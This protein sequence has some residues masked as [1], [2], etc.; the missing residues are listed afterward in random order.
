MPDARSRS[1]GSMF[2]VLEDAVL[3]ADMGLAI[4]EVAGMAA[5]SARAGARAC[6]ADRRRVL[7]GAHV[8]HRIPGLASLD[9][10][11]AQDRF[12]LLPFGDA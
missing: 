11:L 2:V 6:R 5:P 4:A 10:Q 1:R 7:G 9:F 8:A 12:G 3:F